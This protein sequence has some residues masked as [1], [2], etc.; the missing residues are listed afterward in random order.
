MNTKMVTIN[1]K[2]W[3]LGTGWIAQSLRKK[4]KR[5]IHKQSA[6]NKSYTTSFDGSLEL[7]PGLV[8][9]GLG[10]LT[11]CQLKTRKSRCSRS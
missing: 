7:D 9:D 2:Q 11:L 5:K 4:S 1:L 6:R 10:S 3:D 8:S